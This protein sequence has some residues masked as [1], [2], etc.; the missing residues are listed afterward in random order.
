[1]YLISPATA[2]AVVK[3]ATQ[4]RRRSLFKVP[5]FQADSRFDASFDLAGVPNAAPQG[6]VFDW[7]RAELIVGVSDPRGALADATL[8]TGG[9]TYTLVPPEIAQNISSGADQNS[10]LKLTLFAA[11]VQGI[12]K[13][14]SQFDVTTALRFSGAQRIAVLAY[15]KTTHLSAQGDWPS[16]GFDGGFLPVTRTVSAKGFTAEWSLPFIARGVRAEGQS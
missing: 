6:A 1:M 5:V 3:I 7:N 15:G 14:D 16:P 2:S 9:K 12:A 4:E 10:Q 8:T 11:K 13:T